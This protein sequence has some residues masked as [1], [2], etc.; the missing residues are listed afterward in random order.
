MCTITLIR[1]PNS[2][3]TVASFSQAGKRSRHL[4][5]CSQ[6][7]CECS[8]VSREIQ[9]ST[10]PRDGKAELYLATS[11]CVLLNTISRSGNLCAMSLSRKAGEKKSKKQ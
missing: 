4:D 8:Q 3:N 11:Q 7:F 1:H 6:R 2:T 10:L 9:S 5:L